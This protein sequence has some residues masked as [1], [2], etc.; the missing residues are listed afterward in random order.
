[1]NP[2]KVLVQ[3]FSESP[4]LLHALL[5]SLQ[6]DAQDH[7]CKTILQTYLR[8]EKGIHLP[9]ILHGAL[10]I[11]FEE[12]P[13]SI[14]REDR[15][16]VKLIRGYCNAVGHS[17]LKILLDS[18]FIKAKKKDKFGKS[19]KGVV[20][21]VK[22]I[23]DA[24]F[25]TSFPSSI[26]WLFGVIIKQ[27]ESVLLTG[28]INTILGAIFFLR[29][30]VPAVINPVQTKMI[31]PDQVPSNIQGLISVGKLLMALA[32][33]I[34]PE[35]NREYADF[36]K[37]YFPKICQ[38]YIKVANP[39]ESKIVWEEFPVDSS[40]DVK[41]Y[42]LVSS[43]FTQIKEN[44][45]LQHLNSRKRKLEEIENLL[46]ALTPSL[47]KSPLQ[48]SF[49]EIEMWLNQLG[50]SEYSCLFREHNITGE[51]LL[52]LTQEELEQLGISKVGHQKKLLKEISLLQN[53]LYT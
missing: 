51:H 46:N 7:A 33:N 13:Q 15:A 14:L 35:N 36:V 44:T 43:N 49:V 20:K 30:L 10:M 24:L 6:G 27:A 53:M 25:T 18:L 23:V 3:A 17:Y 34:P 38:F 45:S 40:F 48:Y 8:F 42:E 29:F 16:P 9:R 21:E 22:R 2:H 5:R 11:E 28:E 39:D 1:M 50:L 52:D 37:Q 32:N 26:A 31:E 41:F 12:H 4:Y 19:E 47:K